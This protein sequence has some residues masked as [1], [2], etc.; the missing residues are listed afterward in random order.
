MQCILY[1]FFDQSPAHEFTLRSTAH[2][3]R[4][5]AWWISLDV[6]GISYF[7]NFEEKVEM[8][9][10]I[11]NMYSNE[12]GIYVWPHV[13]PTHQGKLTACSNVLALDFKISGFSYWNK[14]GPFLVERTCITP[15]ALMKESMAIFWLCRDNKRGRKEGV[16]EEEVEEVEEEEKGEKEERPSTYPCCVSSRMR[17]CDGKWFTLRA[18]T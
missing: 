14:S 13:G 2:L 11:V 1:M 9:S 7:I 17:S 4:E 8:Q 15:L 10:S 16:V 18:V 6:W 3:F 5:D 12:Y